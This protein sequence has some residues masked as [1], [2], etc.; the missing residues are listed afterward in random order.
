MRALIAVDAE[1]A[2]DDATITP[3]SQIA[4]IPPVSGGML[5]EGFTIDD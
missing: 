3:K 4:V 2:A 1:Y 5:Y